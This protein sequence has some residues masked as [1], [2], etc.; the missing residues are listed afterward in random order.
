MTLGKGHSYS[1]S[2]TASGKQERI[3]ILAVGG[4]QCGVKN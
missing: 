1:Q 3:V 2:P 4:E